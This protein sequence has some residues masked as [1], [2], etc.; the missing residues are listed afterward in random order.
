MGRIPQ[1]FIDDL[2]ARADIVELINSR[3]PLKRKGKEYMACCPFHNEKTPSF[4]VSET[5]QFY[6]CFGCGAHGTALG[7]L[8]QY[9]NMEFVDAIE[10]LADMYN[11][12][13]PREEGPARQQDDKQPLF[14]VLATANSLYQQQLKDSPRAVEYLKNRGLTG[15]IARDYQLGFAPDSWDFLSSRYASD[16]SKTAALEK[17]GMLVNKDSGGHYDRFRDRIMFPIINRR[18]KIIGFGGRILD[19]DKKDAK[20]LNSPENSLFHK[21]MEVYGLY[22]AKRRTRDLKRVVV[23]EGYMDVVALAQYGINYAVACLGTATTREQISQIFRSVHE[24][25]F[26]Y[27]GDMAGRKA[28]WRALQNTLEVIKDG[29]QAK[30]LFLPDGEDPDSMVRQEGREAFEQRLDAAVPLSDFLFDQLG[31]DH[32]VNTL[33]GKASLADA[34]RPLLSRMQESLFKDLLMQRLADL[35]GADIGKLGAST[36]APS[37]DTPRPAATVPSTKRAQAPKGLRNALALLLQYP[38]LSMQQDLDDS[39][40]ASATH[41]LPLLHELYSR[42]R[43]NPQISSSALLERFRDHEDFPALSKLKF[44]D[45]PG[46]DDSNTRAELYRDSIGHLM[47]ATVEQSQQSRLELLNDKVASQGMAALSDEEKEEYKQLISR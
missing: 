34:A 38:E 21:G 33:E 12:E 24:V 31:H 32:D 8:M 4:T 40:A 1:N 10:E 30:F 3:V 27:D 25:I 5:K 11:M 23:V 15:E 42:A 22:Q 39:L 16:Q 35:S 20:Y 7:F 45:I 44:Y 47:A 37:V 2:V 28:A 43:E 14:D 36:A 46:S 6:H 18:G 19:N 13:V 26:C 9:E 29:L 17:T 41:G